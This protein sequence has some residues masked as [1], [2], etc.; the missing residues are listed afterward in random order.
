MPNNPGVDDVKAEECLK[1]AGVSRVWQGP[2]VIDVGSSHDVMDV[3]QAK[4][5]PRP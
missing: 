4:N 2:A 1:A 3:G 5:R